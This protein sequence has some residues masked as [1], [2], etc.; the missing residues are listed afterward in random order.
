LRP[1]KHDELN[2]VSLRKGVQATTAI[3]GNSLSEEEIERIMRNENEG[4]ALSKE[5]QMIEAANVIEAYNAIIRDIDK[6]GTCTAGYEELLSDNR[7]I[8]NGLRMESGIVPGEIRTHSVRVGAYR[9]APPEDCEYLLHR[10]FAWMEEDWGLGK[11]HKTIE[12][13]LKAITAHLYITWIH[14]FGDGNGRSARML[15]FRMLMASGVP[16][17]AAH[18]LTTH[19]NDTRAEYY[20]ALAS[21]SQK[22]AGEN[23]VNFILYALQGFVDAL[24]EQIRIILE[25]QLNVTW[26]NYI[27]NYEFTGALSDAQAR[28]RELLLEISQFTSPITLNELRKRLSQELLAKYAKKTTRAFSR[29]INDLERRNL[30][31]KTGTKILAA[32]SRMRAFLPIRK[33]G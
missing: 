12:G 16:M 30:I 26:E 13:I 22:Q 31:F 6:F 10:L 1:E 5:Y 9:G 14:P 19:Y 28:Q 8:L 7:A 18:L 25:E 15:E 11:N 4:F 23:P 17:T 29:D 27:H 33:Q 20:S 21:T 2:R 24:D 3:E 32:K